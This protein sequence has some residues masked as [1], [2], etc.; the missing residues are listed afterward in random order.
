G[1]LVPPAPPSC[2]LAPPWLPAL[3]WLPLFHSLP[4][5]HVPG[6]PLF[7]CLPLLH[8]LAPAE[9]G[10]RP[11]EW[12]LHPEVV[13]QIWRVFCQTQV[14]LFATRETSQCPLWYSLSHPA[15]LGLDAM[16]QTW[17]RLRQYA[18]PLIALLPGVLERVRHFFPRRSFGTS[19]LSTEVVKTI[20]QSRAPSTRKL[21]ALKW[22]LFTSW[23]GDRPVGTV[24]GFL[25]D[26]F[27]TGLAHSTLKVYVASI[28]AYHAPLHGS[29]VGRNPLVTRFLRGALRPLAS[30]LTPPP[31]LLPSWGWLHI[32]AECPHHFK[33]LTWTCATPGSFS[34]ALAVLFH[35]RQGFDVCVLMQLEFLKG[36]ISGYICNHGSQRERDTA[37]RA[38][39]PRTVRAFKLP[40]LY[41]TPPVTSH[42]STG[43][44]AHVSERGHAGGV[45]IAFRRSVSFPQGTIVTYVT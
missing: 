33:V 1:P 42:F 34:L 29:S 32:A 30:P 26:R 2:Y 27:S 3:P 41:I 11:G 38:I 24:L 17:P 9:A 31:P 44:Y 40:G 6:P 45:P 37:S 19:G 15:P 14:D 10:A 13:K 36:N 8:D 5:F 35:T 28:S 18:F 23:C 20:L 22:K 39:L 12:M 16:V 25:Q 43:L 21:Y 7:H 4:L